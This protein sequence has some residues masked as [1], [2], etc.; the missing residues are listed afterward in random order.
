M[1]ECGV[2]DNFGIPCE[3]ERRHRGKHGYSDAFGRWLTFARGY[4]LEPKKPKKRRPPT[5]QEPR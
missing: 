1:S 2:R 4:V 3:R 5:N